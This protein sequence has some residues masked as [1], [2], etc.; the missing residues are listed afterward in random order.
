MFNLDDRLNKP[1]TC[2][3]E[4]IL[5]DALAMILTQLVQSTLRDLWPLGQNVFSDKTS[6]HCQWWTVQTQIC[7]VSAK[8]ENQFLYPL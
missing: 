1:T 8:N 7:Y 6:E 4:L 3:N 5:F 2:L